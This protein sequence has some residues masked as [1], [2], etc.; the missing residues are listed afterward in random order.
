[1]TKFIAGTLAIIPYMGNKIICKEKDNYKSAK[2]A[3]LKNTMKDYIIFILIVI[4]NFLF[5]IIDRAY[6]YFFGTFQSIELFILSFLMKI[7]TDFKFY[8]FKILSL[9]LFSIFSIILDCLKPDNYK[10][11][12]SDIIIGFID[13]ILDSIDYTYK[14]YLME[15]KY[16]SPYKV[17]FILYFT[18]LIDATIY[19]IIGN[20][21]GNF[22]YLNG[23][24]VNLTKVKKNISIYLKIAKSIPLIISYMFFYSFFY[25]IIDETTVIHGEIINIIFQLIVQLGSLYQNNTLTK[26]L[27]MLVCNICLILSLLIYIEIIQ[28]NFCGLNSNLRR[29]ILERE[30]IDQKIIYENLDKNDEKENMKIEVGKGYVVELNRIS[31]DEEE[32]EF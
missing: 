28:F 13:I 24:T 21:Y 10:F 23:K 17:C 18:Y 15:V 1:M 4:M 3:L 2:K 27:I 25:V 20:T 14:K 26:F 22:I 31:K 29:N 7:Y 32:I 11:T 6:D 16:F 19:E 5:F 30:E 9:I 12:F 8:N